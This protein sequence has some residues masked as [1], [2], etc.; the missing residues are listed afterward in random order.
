MNAPSVLIVEDDA[1]FRASVATLVK[2][3]G[4]VVREA[5]SLAQAREAF[6]DAAPDVVLLDLALP[7]GDGLEL[8]RD[9]DVGEA[10]EFV[11]MT[12]ITAVENV[13]AALREGVV[14]YLPK[15]FSATHF[16]VLL[17]RAAHAVSVARQ[18]EAAEV[19]P[20]SDGEDVFRA[21]RS[22]QFRSLLDVARRVAHTDASVFITGE[23][24]TGKEMLARYIHEHRLHRSDVLRDTLSELLASGTPVTDLQ[25]MIS[26]DWTQDIDWSSEAIQVDVTRDAIKGSPKYDASQPINREMEVQLYDFHGRPYYW[27][28]T[29]RS[30]SQESSA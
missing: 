14:D 12:G 24:G 28:A 27:T 3:E 7:D 21:R 18:S 19:E 15:P 13:I 9:D 20:V 16:Q 17:G 25:V 6:E 5:G 10:T 1:D 4:F 26:P 2:R 8:L 30:Q 22:S 11:V 23:S 29:Q